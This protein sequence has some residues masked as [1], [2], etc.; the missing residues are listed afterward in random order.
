MD[1]R[2]KI[3]AELDVTRL[4][5]IE[6]GPQDKPLL[7]RPINGSGSVLYVDHADTAE[8]R[9]KYETD[10]TVN[11]NALIEVDAVWGDRTLPQILQEHAAV[12]P[13]T[14]TQVDYVVASHVVEHVPDLVGWLSE[15]HDV[16]K[17]TGQLRLAV[18]DRR[19]TFD[20]LREDSRLSD[21]L[22]AYLAGARSPT[23]QAVL[24]SHLNHASG[25]DHIKLW[26]DASVPPLPHLDWNYAI[27]SAREAMAGVYHDVHCWAVTPYS[28]ADI[29][30]ALAEH[31]LLH[32]ACAKFDDTADGNF[33]FYLRMIPC[34][35]PSMAA[36]SW[37]RVRRD[38]R[39]TVPGSRFRPIDVLSSV[40]AVSAPV[41][42]ATPMVP[43][44]GSAEQV[45]QGR[46]A[47]E[48]LL[49]VQ[50]MEERARVGESLAEER[51]QLVRR[52]EA[53]ALAS[54]VLSN[55]R[56]HLVQ[57]MEARAVRAEA[58]LDQVRRSASGRVIEPLRAIARTLRR[59]RS[60]GT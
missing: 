4:A 12:H 23:P 13:G 10:A 17:P 51:L 39:Q 48:R 35:Q 3:L 18:P 6:I 25:A 49:L 29:F 22:A 58:A 8:L 26:E 57:K 24:D 45:H 7:R 54:E 5:G 56:L 14:P 52:M 27:S 21:V 1:R 32:L 44:N 36:E 31:G 37:R 34:D 47:H 46:L 2:E 42:S 9:R 43:C 38:A 41:A 30:V 53:R 55:E 40:T 16:L 59:D 15:I 20:C 60:S 50:A 19:F 11:L 28:L 33:E